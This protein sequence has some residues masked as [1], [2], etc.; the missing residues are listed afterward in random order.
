MYALKTQKY[1]RVSDSTIDTFLFTTFDEVKEVFDKMF[2]VAN[3]VKEVKT[4]LHSPSL[5]KM[6]WEGQDWNLYSAKV[7]FREEIVSYPKDVIDN[8]IED[9]DLYSEEED[10]SADSTD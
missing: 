1:F 10:E 5:F 4:T 6:E 2:A 9:F 3:K 7:W 8:F